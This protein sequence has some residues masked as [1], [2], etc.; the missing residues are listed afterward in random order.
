[1]PIVIL[2]IGV[3]LVIAG[4]NNKMGELGELLK[5][6]FTSSGTIPPFLVLI[7]VGMLLSN[8]G[9]FPKFAEALQ[10]KIPLT[11][12]IRNSEYV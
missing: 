3:M 2:A 5:D 10:G 6:D 1:M 11:T 12:P 4:I 9:F 7:I 8:K